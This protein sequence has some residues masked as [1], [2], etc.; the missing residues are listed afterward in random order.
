M[1]RMM[2][3]CV[4]TKTHLTE[5]RDGVLRFERG[6]GEV[7]SLTLGKEYEVLSEDQEFYRI[8]DDTDEA[9]WYP[10]SMFRLSWPAG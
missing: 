5:G 8:V 9:Y 10:K 4:D 7:V 1:A 3:V 2:V 6:E